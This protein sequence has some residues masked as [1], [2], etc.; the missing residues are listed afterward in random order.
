MLWWTS[1][2]RFSHKTNM[3][4]Q[5]SWLVFLLL[6][7][8]NRIL[9]YPTISLLYHTEESFQHGRTRP[10]D[11][12]CLRSYL[13]WSMSTSSRILSSG[14]CGRGGLPCPHSYLLLI[15]LNPSYSLRRA[16]VFFLYTSVASRN[17]QDSAHAFRGLGYLD[18]HQDVLTLEFPVQ[19][20][21]AETIHEVDLVTHGSHGHRHAKRKK[22]KAPEEK[23][24]QV[25]LAQDKTAL[26]SRKGDTGSVLWRARCVSSRHQDRAILTST[27]GH[28]AWSLH[29]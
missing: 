16:Q 10:C 6:S 18:S 1:R 11:Y 8:F 12:C 19:V 29:N 3:A 20:E 17:V 5:W 7:I 26:R 25:Q 24:L 14:R 28:A 9:S 2:T 21:V 23:T 4:Q 27:A 22:R 13:T 15:A